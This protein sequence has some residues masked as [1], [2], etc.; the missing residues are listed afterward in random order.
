MCEIE[1]PRA[2]RLD[3]ANTMLHLVPTESYYGNDVAR[4]MTWFQTS[5]RYGIIVFVSPIDN[6]LWSIEVQAKDN[7]DG[8]LSDPQIWRKVLRSIRIK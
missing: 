1:N 3:E 5:N 6:M 4:F 8:I 2:T 7:K